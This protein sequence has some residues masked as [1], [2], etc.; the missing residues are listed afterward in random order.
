MRKSLIFMLATA[1]LTVPAQAQFL[2]RLTDRALNAAERGVTKAV[3]KSVEKTTEKATNKILGTA[4]KAVEKEVDKTAEAVGNAATNATQ[5]YTNSI[6][7]SANEV[8]ASA[9]ELN[10]VTDSIRTAN[11]QPASTSGGGMAGLMSSYM[12]LMGAGNDT[13][14]YMLDDESQ[15]EVSFVWNEIYKADGTLAA[16]N[17]LL[18]TSSDTGFS[19][20]YFTI[21]VANGMRGNA[22]V[23]LKKKVQDGLQTDPTQPN[24]VGD[25]PKYHTNN[26]ILWSWHLWVTDYDPYVPMTVESGTYIYSVPNGEIHRYAGTTWTSLEYS[27]AFMMD[28]NLGAEAALI[29]TNELVKT[30]GLYYQWG[31]K[32][33]FPNTGSVTTKASDSTNEPGVGTPKQNIRYSVHNPAVFITIGS[34]GNGNWTAYE[35]V[36]VGNASVPT[37]GDGTAI[38]N[39]HKSD[40]STDDCE[41]GKSFYDP[42]P[43]GWRV[44]KDGTWS[45]FSNSTS[46]WPGKPAPQGRFYYPGGISSGNGRVWY[47]ASGY[48]T[49]AGAVSAHETG[50][51]SLSST[52]KDAGKGYYFALTVANPIPS[53]SDFRTYASAVRCIRLSHALPY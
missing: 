49:T 26:D 18:V 27:K 42:C 17:E 35:Y 3:E 23:A 34:G 29:N 14:H 19:N 24:Y 21:R 44:P 37:L 6:I 4:E 13:P 30:Y 9:T 41:E 22:L 15:W 16:A 38:W 5:A 40:H 2:N 52:P 8:N 51:N 7:E 36:T 10:R 50:G 32:D 53:H 28:R 25:D 33:P 46:V 43:Y 20:K 12:T 11:G 47:P 1:L 39:D 45:D 31:R 48:R